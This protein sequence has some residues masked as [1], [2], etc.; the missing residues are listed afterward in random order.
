MEGKWTT[1]DQGIPVISWKLIYTDNT[2]KMILLENKLY[3]KKI[4]I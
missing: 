3:V 4:G 2:V 1:L